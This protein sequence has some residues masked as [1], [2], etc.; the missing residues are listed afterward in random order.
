MA[1]QLSSPSSIHSAWQTSFHHLKI[2]FTTAFFIL[3]FFTTL[4]CNIS[5]WKITLLLQMLC[6]VGKAWVDYESINLWALLQ[7]SRY[8]TDFVF[9]RLCWK[10]L[11][12]ISLWERLIWCSQAIKKW[13]PLWVQCLSSQVCFCACPSNRDNFLDRDNFII[14]ATYS[15]S[16]HPLIFGQLSYN[17]SASN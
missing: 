6:Q 7:K 4:V 9:H 13:W 8:A 14:G 12:F 16:L 5:Y 15:V 17:T 2:F 10:I 1:C 3:L 11:D